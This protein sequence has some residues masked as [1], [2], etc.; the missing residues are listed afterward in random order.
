LSI[1]AVSSLAG[2]YQL[3]LRANSDINYL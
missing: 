2:Q 3:A 1:N